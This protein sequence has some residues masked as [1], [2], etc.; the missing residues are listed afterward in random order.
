MR[1]ILLKDVD[2]VGKKHEVV[3]VSG[4][5]ARNLLIKKGLAREASAADVS[6]SQKIEEQRALN[7]EKEL[8][9][10]QKSA[11]KLE[12]MEVE[13]EMKVGEKG[14]LFEAVTTHKIAERLSEEGISVK[15]EQIDLKEPIKDLGKFKTKVLFKHG[16]EANI[17]IIVN[18]EKS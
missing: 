15:K 5:Y 2:G 11:E 1:V 17:E 9:E 4:G 8:V 14:Q 10:A 7:A 12:G 18:E 16:I 3:N 6:F 13:V